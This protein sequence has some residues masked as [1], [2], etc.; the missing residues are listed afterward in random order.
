MR[1][2]VSG[3]GTFFCLLSSPVFLSARWCVPPLTSNSSWNVSST[4]HTEMMFPPPGKTSYTL[5][6]FPQ[7]FDHTLSFIAALFLLLYLLYSPMDPHGWI[8]NRCTQR[9]LSSWTKHGAAT[10]NLAIPSQW[11]VNFFFFTSPYLFLSAPSHY[12]KSPWSVK[13]V[14][15]LP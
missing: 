1:T 8:Q 10:H 7:A 14:S 3:E 15:T 13:C 5:S 9:V 11:P 6:V 12:Y 2:W 4:L